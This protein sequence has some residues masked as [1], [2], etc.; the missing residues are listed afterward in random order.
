MLT[1]PQTML[2]PALEVNFFPKG[3]QPR[4]SRSTKEESVDAHT[5]SQYNTDPNKIVV[6]CMCIS[7][8]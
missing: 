5:V 6:C 3:F 2:L 4:P 8:V 1:G 7:N